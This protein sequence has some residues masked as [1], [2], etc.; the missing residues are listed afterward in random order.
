[1]GLLSDKQLFKLKISLN[2]IL[3]SIPSQLISTGDS[4]LTLLNVEVNP[5]FIMDFL[6]QPTYPVSLE[7]SYELDWGAIKLVISYSNRFTHYHP[8]R[9][10][11]TI[12][13]NRSLVVTYLLL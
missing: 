3:S 4:L 8:L 9:I 6:L 5:C 11:D 12:I 10:A 2:W 7:K 13:C 1:M